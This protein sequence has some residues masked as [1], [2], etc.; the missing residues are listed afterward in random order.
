MGKGIAYQFKLAFP[1]NYNDYVKACKSGTLRIGTLHYYQEN[2]KIIINFPTK[3]KWRANSKLEYI[4]A[5]LDKLIILIRKLGISSIAIPPLGSGN[6]GL[7]WAD[8][9][10]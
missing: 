4:E 8:E 3:D 1:Q 6:G 10:N 9:K 2:D 5:G 7:R